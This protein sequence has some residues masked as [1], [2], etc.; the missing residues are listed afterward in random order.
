[1][2]CNEDETEESTFLLNLWIDSVASDKNDLIE[3]ECIPFSFLGTAN[4]A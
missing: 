3:K 2:G 4:R 1:M